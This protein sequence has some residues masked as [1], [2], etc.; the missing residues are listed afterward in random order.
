VKP[1]RTWVELNE[2][3]RSADEKTC[4]QLLKV[5][6]DGPKRKVFALRIHSRLNRVRAA[7]ERKEIG[8]AIKG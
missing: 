7:R 1:I 8:N 4:E 3:I 6:L 2:I 5:E